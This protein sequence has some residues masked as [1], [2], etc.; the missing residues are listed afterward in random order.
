MSDTPIP[1]PDGPGRGRQGFGQ[2]VERL[3]QLYA[4]ACLVVLFTLLLVEV[5]CRMLR[6]EFYWGS[7]LSGIL[8]AWLTVFCL[9]WITRNRSHLSADVATVSLPEGARRVLRYLG[10]AAMLAYLAALVWFCGD[11]ALKNFHGG[12]RDAGIL[13]L[14]LSILQFGVTIGLALTFVSQCLL[15]L[16]EGAAR[17][18]DQ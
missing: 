17:D 3:A 12:V 5:A 14:P 10:Y 8:M 9:P 18:L 1:A 13:R 15:M 6:I 7:E 2:G 16:R 11:L 4:S